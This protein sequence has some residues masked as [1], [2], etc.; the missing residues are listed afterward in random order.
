MFNRLDQTMFDAFSHEN[1]LANEAIFSRRWNNAINLW[2]YTTA[3]PFSIST[4]SEKK[5]K[6]KW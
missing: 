2:W 5:K 4:F 3:A 1:S 6:I